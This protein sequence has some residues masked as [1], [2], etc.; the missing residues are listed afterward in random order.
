M[1]LNSAQSIS[2]EYIMKITQRE[3]FFFFLGGRGGV[4]VVVMEVGRVKEMINTQPHWLDQFLHNK[5]SMN[6][7]KTKSSFAYMVLD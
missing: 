1:T 4:V 2:V 6:Y 3:F 5:Y 7:S